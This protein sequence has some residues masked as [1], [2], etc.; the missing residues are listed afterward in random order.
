MGGAPMSYQPNAMLTH[1]PLEGTVSAPPPTHH[2]MDASYEQNLYP[3]YPVHYD[4]NDQSLDFGEQKEGVPISNP[5]EPNPQP[6][7]STFGGPPNSPS[8]NGSRFRLNQVKEVC[9]ACHKTVYF[10]EKTF[11]PASLIYH[12]LCLRCNACN[13][14]LNA[15][16]WVDHDRQ[17]YCKGCYAKYFGPRGIGFGTLAFA[18]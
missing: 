11:G 9:T 8:K 16:Q 6:P 7:E 10:A 2:P 3:N 12:K 4:P 13:N 18:S 17:P 1:A 15:G 14:L 5:I